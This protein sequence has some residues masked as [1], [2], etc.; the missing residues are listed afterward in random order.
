MVTVTREMCDARVVRLAAGTALAAAMLAGTATGA[1]AAARTTVADGN[2][3]ADATWGGAGKKP[4]A[5]DDVTV[6]HGVTFDASTPALK[7]VTIGSGATATFKGWNTKLRATTVTVNGTITHN[8]QTQELPGGHAIAPDNNHS[9]WK[10]DNRIWIVCSSLTVAAGKAIDATG[11]GY[12]GGKAAYGGGSGPGGAESQKGYGGTHGG[13]GWGNPAAA[14]GS[15][16]RPVG[17]G[18]GGSITTHQGDCTGH[19]GGVV[20]IEATGTVTVNGTISVNGSDTSRHQDGGASGGSVWITCRAFKGSGLVSANGGPAS[21][22]TPS[23]CGGGGGRV[24][25]EIDAAAQARVTSTPRL[26]V[27]AGA[28]RSAPGAPGTLHVSHPK[29]LPETFRGGVVISWP[30]GIDWKPNSLTFN[31]G[32]YSVASGRTIKVDG[33]VSL[34]AQ[35]SLGNYTTL[36]CNNL[37]LKDSAKL[38][39]HAGGADKTWPKYGALVSVGNSM[40]VHTNCVVYPASDPG[41]GGSVLFETGNLTIHPGGSFNADVRGYSGGTSKHPNGYGPGGGGGKLDG[42]GSG[43]S[44]GGAGG[45][46]ARW[47][48]PGGA[49][50]GATNAP[51]QPGSGGGRGRNI[52]GGAGGGG[53][54]IRATGDVTVN[55]PISANG[56]RSH[57]DTNCDNGGGAGG[58]VLIVCRKFLGTANISANGGSANGQWKGQGQGGGGRIAIWHNTALDL[59]DKYV[60]TGDG[61]NRLSTNA[62]G[63]YTGKLLVNGGVNERGGAELAGKPGTT[64]FG[65]IRPLQSAVVLLP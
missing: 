46:S 44:Y 7:S 61:I 40:D 51:S 29:A 6:A 8:R 22:A 53:V 48:A 65:R 38:Y 36:T 58:S 24:A 12:I 9:N 20:R 25:I 10:P 55:G 13:S 16:T 28:H 59:L 19:G 33:D 11:K 56:G 31:S 17:P 39:V 21:A 30:K 3:S 63:T 49:T 1:R 50:Y 64:V 35:L 15:V 26:S 37:L 27:G 23:R 32:A 60:A 45:R 14:Y 41:K 4:V 42:T 57:F 47:H 2:W 43:G 5:G 34:L 62:P 52:D 54:W 18:S